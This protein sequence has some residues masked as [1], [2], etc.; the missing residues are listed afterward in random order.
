MLGD[1]NVDAAVAIVDDALILI[2]FP[3]LTRKISSKLGPNTVV[4]ASRNLD[5]ADMVFPGG[6]KT[7]VR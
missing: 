1:G 6:I 7:L 2:P 4:R 3:A 5:V